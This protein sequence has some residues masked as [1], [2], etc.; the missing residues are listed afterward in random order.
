MSMHVLGNFDVGVVGKQFLWGGCYVVE[1]LENTLPEKKSFVRVIHAQLLSTIYQLFA[2]KRGRF[3]PRFCKD[4]VC[5]I[6]NEN[7]FQIIMG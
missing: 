6:G 7:N 2:S 3:Q 4:L 5:N 1:L